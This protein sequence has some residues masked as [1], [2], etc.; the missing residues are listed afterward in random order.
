MKLQIYKDFIKSL[1][2]VS[3]SSDE[4]FAFQSQ[5]WRTC[6]KYKIAAENTSKIILNAIEDFCHNKTILFPSFSNDIIKYKKFDLTKSLPYTGILPCYC[7][8][9]EKFKRTFSP[10]HGFLVKGP[11]SKEILNLKQFSTWGKNSVFEWLEKKNARWVAINLKWSE[12]C[13][14]HHRSEEVAKVP[15]RYYINYYGKLFNNGKYIKN[16]KEKKYSYSLKVK[17]K[18]N[19]NIWPKIFKKDDT[20]EYLYNEGIKLRSALTKTITKRSV[21]LFRNDPYV[22]ITNKNQV[23]RWVKLEK[24]KEVEKQDI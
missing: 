7:L 18:F 20:R 16:I 22:S 14:F 19:F 24:T 11:K 13:A 17:P 23:K 5:I 8:K 9:S 12:G 10:L 3:D 15:Y 4:I 21:E 6:L 2:K 1:E